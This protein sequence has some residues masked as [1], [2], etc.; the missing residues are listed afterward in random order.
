MERRLFTFVLASSAFFVVYMGLRILFD[1]QPPP[2]AN[3][4]PAGVRPAAESLADADTPSDADDATAADD[5]ETADNAEATTDSDP[6]VAAES[7]DE[8]AAQTQAEDA[9]A[10]DRPGRQTWASLGSMAPDSPYFMMV[11]LTNRGGGIERIELTER[12]ENGRLKYRR[13]DTR[14]GYMGYLAGQPASRIDGVA[15]NV[16]GQGTPAATAVA[17][18][19]EIGLRVG[20]VVIAVAGTP[21]T[22]ADEIDQALIDTEPGDEVTLEVIRGKPQNDPESDSASSSDQTLVFKVTLTEHPLDLVRLA[23]QGGP[24]QVPGNLTRLSCL[25]SLEKINRKSIPAGGS[26][27]NGM[28]DATAALW[29]SE[30]TPADDGDADKPAGDLRAVFRLPLSAADLDDASSGLEMQRGY[31]VRPGSY[32]IGLDVQ[33]RNP[34]DSPQEVAY[35]LEGVNGMTLEGW[36]YS[37]KISPNWGGAAARDVVYK[38]PAMGHDLISGYAMLKQARNEPQSPNHVIFAPDG[39]D[40]SKQLSYI[41][42]DAQYFTVAYVPGEGEAMN[43]F[44]RAVAGIVAD[45]KAIPDD[46][47]RAVNVSF[48]VDSNVAQLGPGESL[49]EQLV[50]FAGPKRP[51]LLANYG[52]G[53]TIYYGWFSWPAKLLA[54][55]LHFMYSL[56]GNYAVAIVMLTV[57]VRG[58]MF[59]LSRKAAI[60]AQKMQELAPEMKKIAEKYKDDMEGRLKAQRELQQRVGFN[61]MAGCLPMF[62]QLPIFIGLYRALSVDIE[63]RQAAFASWTNWASNLAGPDMLAY[64][65]DWLWEYLSGRGTGWLGP[66]FNILPVVVMGLFLMQQKMFMPPATDEQTEMT[67]K[68]M[69]YMT[70]VMGLFFFRVPAGLCIYFITSS[71]WGICERMIVKRTIPQGKHFD[72]AVLEGTAAR[73]SS[74][75]SLADRLRQQLAPEEPQAERPNKRK[76][77]VIT[78]KGGKKRR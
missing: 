40:R 15:V 65:G 50:L 52:L 17:E 22:T 42:V 34:G 28:L 77:P 72:S 10:V 57:V 26:R 37:N 66:Y 20:D 16:V 45:P 29:E 48:Y 64:W 60:N 2:P 31:T 69:T 74:S 12:N 8:S 18:S 11:T 56:I 19:G 5:S 54:G 51:E 35:R 46:Q 53:D 73:S 44:R 71:L 68:V 1:V 27:I 39:D 32:D 61:P 58:M 9:E 14:S 24:E 33:I 30:I 7:A 47:E 25:L 63:L 36:W 21:V 59:P 62:L 67:Q 78:Q 4:D 76:R 6:I 55:V 49:Q 13:V 75:S 38:T 41:G 43:S 3:G 70:L 23:S